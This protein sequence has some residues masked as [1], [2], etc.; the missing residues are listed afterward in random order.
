MWQKTILMIALQLGA[1]G[2]DAYYTDHNLESFRGSSRGTE[3]NP[4]SGPFV[5]TR[6]SR[7]AYFSVTAG[8]K[9][10]APHILRKRGH[11]RLASIV[12]ISG[13]ADNALGA[14]SSKRGQTE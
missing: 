1:S 13:I 5:Q 3:N 11:N 14:A 9:I 10:A 12:A 2:F 4:L 6:A 8:I 7:I